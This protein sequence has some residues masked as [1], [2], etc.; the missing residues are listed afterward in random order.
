MSEDETEAMLAEAL[1]LRNEFGDA[2]YEAFLASCPSHAARL[3]A[4]IARLDHALPTTPSNPAP[5]SPPGYRLGRRLGGGALGEVYAATTSRGDAVAVKYLHPWLAGDDVAR[6]RFMLEGESLRRLKHEN[7]AAWLDSGEHGGRPYLV[8]ELLAGATLEEAIAAAAEAGRPRSPAGLLAAV[9][10]LA[11]E[12]DPEAADADAPRL[13]G[14][15]WFTAVARLGRDA[16]RGVA[17][18]HERGVLH[19]DLKPSNLL[20]TVDGRLVVIDFG[21]AFQIGGERLTATN[22]PVG[23]P[24]YAPPETLRGEATPPDAR[25]DVWALGV[26]LHEMI[27][28]EH[29]FAGRSLAGTL[30]KLIEADAPPLPPQ[31]PR[32]LG[33]VVARATAPERGLRYPTMDAFAEDLA[34]FL[35][36]RPVTA[37]PP[38]AWAAMRRAARRRPALTTALVTVVVAATTLLFRELR[39][40]DALREE[41]DAKAA[42]LERSREVVA[43]NEIQALLARLEELWP[44]E[45]AVVRGDWGMERWLNDARRLAATRGEAEERRRRLLAESPRADVPDA[46][47][48][49]LVAGELRALDDSAKGVEKHMGYGKRTQR[50]LIARERRRWARE[51]L[52]LP[53]SGFAESVRV[54]TAVETV[55]ALDDLDLAIPEVEARRAR[56][57]DVARRSLIEGADAWRACGEAIADPARKP[58]YRGLRLRPQTGLSPL[59]FDPDSGLAEFAHLASGPPAVRDPATGKLVYDQATGIVLVLLPGGKCSIGVR[60]PNPGESIHLPYVDPDAQDHDSPPTEHDLA[61]FFVAKHETTQAQWAYGMR[62]APKTPSTM[63]SVPPTDATLDPRVPV[64]RVN[65][66]EATEMAR[67]LGLRLPTSAQWDYAARGGTTSRWW[68]GDDPSTLLG[69]ANGADRRFVVSRPW[70]DG[71][72]KALDFD[73]G[74]ERHAPVGVLRANPFGLHDVHGNVREWCIDGQQP[75]ADTPLDPATGERW[76]R[77]DGG[78]AALGGSWASY[79]LRMRIGQRGG[80]EIVERGEDLGF[81]TA[82]RID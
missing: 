71:L 58:Q 48:E 5:P 47:R 43:L 13:L 56:A 27:A 52:L 55:D 19:R 66:S 81:R 69:A 2:A 34:A 40:T 4:A 36:D 75:L 25:G 80:T 77:P 61:P 26:T 65:W 50:D 67:R 76:V 73:D 14:P 62:A 3:R 44:A 70:S 37:R 64:H 6:R 8:C 22:V 79:P 41:R 32:D 21:L 49:R 12:G 18:A 15:D 63:L 72:E 24:A 45:P 30:K 7:A 60:K 82:R 28:G 29:P 1:R 11:G 9:R 39:A 42:A 54:R 35:E 57:D 46:V 17:H 59:G 38:S 33:A 74:F 51:A 31:T 20:L 53:Y 23:T 68:T 10:T 16:A 78:R